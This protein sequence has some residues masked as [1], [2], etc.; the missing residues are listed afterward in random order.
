M[1]VRA[2][3]NNSS[4]PSRVWAYISVS[5]SHVK[6]VVN[7]SGVVR[8]PLEAPRPHI[9]VWRPWHARSSSPNRG[10]LPK[11]QSWNTQSA[12][13]EQR[14]LSSTGYSDCAAVQTSPTSPLSHRCS[15][16]NSVYELKQTTEVNRPFSW[17]FWARKY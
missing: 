10:I 1:I 2:L 3:D 5:L 6:D 12:F 14:Y 8:S 11:L 13:D 7:D 16:A 15:R 17:S 9:V 4:Q